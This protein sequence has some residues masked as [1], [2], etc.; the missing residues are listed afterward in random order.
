MNELEQTG[1][2]TANNTAE[3]KPD[4]ASQPLLFVC[5]G[6]TI[7]EHR[8]QGLQTIGRAGSAENADITIA[9]RYISERHGFFNTFNEYTTYT[10]SK[11]D[12][13]I[14]YQG[15]FLEPGET[16]VMHDG[17]ELFIPSIGED[18]YD[19]IMLVYVNS[20][21]RKTVWQ[22]LQQ[23]SRD[24][25][26]GMYNGKTFTLWWQQHN[27]NP[28]YVHAYLFLLDIDSFKQFNEQYGHHTGDQAIQAIAEL[29]TNAVRYEHQVCRWGGDKFVGI[30]PGSPDR[31]EARL[32]HLQKSVSELGTKMNY[33]ISVSIGYTD[34]DTV[35]DRVDIEALVKHAEQAL[36]QTES[37]G[38]KKFEPEQ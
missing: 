11:T 10:A 9:N 7:T 2:M 28:D 32:L 37:G 18:P 24:R 22:E 34:I 38:L 19:A 6:R 15:R 35:S 30:I 33:P 20:M 26:T 4:A 21:I 25:L 12:N 3:Q 31:V 27:M 1:V 29:I 17:D 5:Y 16:I 36:Q 13:G 8:L 23:S 14:K